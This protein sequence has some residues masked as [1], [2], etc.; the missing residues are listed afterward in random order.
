MKDRPL[1]S[2]TQ[3]LDDETGIY[4]GDLCDFSIH[5]EVDDF[6]N[7][8]GEDGAKEICET[9]DYLKKAVMEDYLPRAQ[10]KKESSGQI[11]IK[12]S[13]SQWEYIGNKT[14]WTKEIK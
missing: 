10:N 12:L 4:A 14:G 11:K 7:R 3:I 2:V 9:L 6:L 5:G 8:Y 13:K 1:L